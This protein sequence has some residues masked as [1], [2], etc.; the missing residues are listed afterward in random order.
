[1][2]KAIVLVSGG[3]DS[4]T[5]LAIASNQ[6]YTSYALSFDY[7]QRS[8]SELEAAARVVK[9]YSVAAHKVIELKM[10]EFGGSALTDDSIDVPE[11]ETKGI[12]VTYVPARNTVF[13]SYALAWAEVVEADAIFI[14]VNALDYSGYPDCRPEYIEAFQALINLATKT[15]V[16]GRY[17]ALETPLINLSKADIIRAG[18]SL[19]VDYAA[20]VSCYQA[21][22][23]GRACGACDSCRLRRKGFSDAKVDDPTRYQ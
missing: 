2:K 18:A 23:E 10:G 21:D 12:P 15:G 3:L 9:A 11:A 1:M 7:G 4:A 6:G 8:L 22:S 19:G 20:T 14:G 13:L 17:I 5:C 16:E